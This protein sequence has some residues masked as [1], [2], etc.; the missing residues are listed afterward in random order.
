M[1]KRMVKSVFDK[2]AFWEDWQVQ[3]FFY[4][5]VLIVCI[6]ISFSFG[7]RLLIIPSGN[8]KVIKQS[9]VVQVAP[10]SKK[11]FILYKWDNEEYEIVFH[12][13]DPFQIQIP[14]E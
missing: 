2:I 14:K 4:S 11:L 6:G 9:D 13:S 3:I 7:N 1:F 10:I 5:V 8:E 12:I